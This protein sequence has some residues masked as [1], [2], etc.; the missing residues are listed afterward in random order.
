LSIVNGLLALFSSIANGEIALERRSIGVAIA[1]R[2]IVSEANCR[3]EYR[4]KTP[5]QAVWPRI[6]VSVA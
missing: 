3:V 2:K 5:T 6:A 4:E 1:C